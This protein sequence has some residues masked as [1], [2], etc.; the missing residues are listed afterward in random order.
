MGWTIY[1]VV[2]KYVVLL[3]GW[4]H[5]ML[6]YMYMAQFF[7]CDARFFV[8]LFLYE[9]LLDV[10]WCFLLAAMVII[11]ILAVMIDV[12]SFSRLCLLVCLFAL[13]GFSF[14]VGFSLFCF[15]GL[16][17]RRYIEHAYRSLFCSNLRHY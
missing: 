10:A 2:S 3:A 8:S 4:F 9:F 13:I 7:F 12:L 11:S 14:F 16:G 1:I 6:I 15:V 17:W 5:Y